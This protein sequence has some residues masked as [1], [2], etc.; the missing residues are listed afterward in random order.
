[1]HLV[2]LNCS[3]DLLLKAILT[4]SGHN[5][6]NTPLVPISK[7][8]LP[9]MHIKSGVAGVILNWITSIPKKIKKLI[10]KET[11]KEPVKSK[12]LEKELRNRKSSRKTNKVNYI[13]TNHESSDDE[14][15]VEVQANG[16]RKNVEPYGESNKRALEYLKSKFGTNFSASSPQGKQVNQL[17]DKNDEFCS[18]LEEHQKKVWLQF[19]AVVNGF[20]GKKRDENYV[21]LIQELK[22][23]MKE[24]RI[25]CTPK[26]HI[27]LCHYNQ[28][29]E[30]NSD[31]SEEAGE[32]FHHEMYAQMEKFKVSNKNLNRVLADYFWRLTRSPESKAVKRKFKNKSYFKN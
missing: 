16:K 19:S 28:F 23:S 2:K 1:M 22:K 20:L 11:K 15:D 30:S 18:H 9:V 32:K 6:V 29:A 5:R 4:F 27:L 14:S 10:K 31:F 12:K 13:E 8:L 17:I 3:Y 7:I 25:K 21:E 24:N 26:V